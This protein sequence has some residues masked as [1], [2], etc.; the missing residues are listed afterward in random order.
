VEAWAA[1]TGEE[2]EARVGLG[3]AEA[4]R[5]DGG[6]RIGGELL[7]RGGVGADPAGGAGETPAGGKQEDSGGA[8]R[9]GV[10]F[11]TAES[12]KVLGAV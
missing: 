5:A 7:V 8:A 9:R 1:P 6:G 3:A 11:E 12:D 2:L 10:F 4:L